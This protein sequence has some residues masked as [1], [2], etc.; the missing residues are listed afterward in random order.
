MRVSSYHFDVKPIHRNFL[1]LFLLFHRVDPGQASARKKVTQGRAA[2]IGTGTNR[3]GPDGA[4]TLSE[5][6]ADSSTMLEET[7]GTR[8]SKKSKN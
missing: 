6:D 7:E 5:L 1:T 8:A 2:N 3:A 4:R